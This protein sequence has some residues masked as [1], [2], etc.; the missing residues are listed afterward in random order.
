MPGAV[1]REVQAACR[2]TIDLGR[3]AGEDRTL[4]NNFVDIV[5]EHLTARE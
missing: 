3:K 5:R 4:A 1:Y 2:T